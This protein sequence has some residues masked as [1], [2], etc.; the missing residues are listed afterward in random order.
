[1]GAALPVSSE[2]E[3]RAAL[4]RRR[5]LRFASGVLILNGVLG[6]VSLAIAFAYVSRPLGDVEVFD[7]SVN[8]SR[9]ELVETLRQT[10]ETIAGAQSAFD[11]LDASLADARESS[12]SAATVARGLSATM[13][14]LGE[15]MNVTILGTQPLAGLVPSFR[16]AGEQLNELGTNLDSMTAALARNSADIERTRTDLGALRGQVDQ[17]TTTVEETEIPT[18][19]NSVAG[20][21]RLALFALMAWLAVFA[22]SSLLV[23]VALWRGLHPR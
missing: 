8:D 21:L 3:I 13:S 11:G 12:T 5:W 7:T 20:V 4:T 14:G 16:R 18:S 22:A 19:V 23:G 6:L 10:G 9:T 15:A 17:L 1:M 2:F